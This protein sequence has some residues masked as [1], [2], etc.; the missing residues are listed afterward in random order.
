MYCLSTC[1]NTTEFVHTLFLRF[2]TTTLLLKLI[3]LHDCIRL[4]RDAISV[5][6]LL[7]KICLKCNFIEKFE[8]TIIIRVLD[9]V[10]Y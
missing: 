3:V 6:T 1:L 5:N 10:I 7:V 2:K 8:S 4:V 9:G